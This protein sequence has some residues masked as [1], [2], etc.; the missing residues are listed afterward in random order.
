M[1][2]AAWV[3]RVL[4]LR[5]DFTDDLRIDRTYEE[6]YQICQALLQRDLVKAQGLMKEHI[7]YSE[8]FVKN[9]TLTQLERAR[10]GASRNRFR[11]SGES[12]P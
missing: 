2:S 10:H 3:R 9:L 11:Q 5:L 6:H 4:P 8:N 1:G 12:L 7:S